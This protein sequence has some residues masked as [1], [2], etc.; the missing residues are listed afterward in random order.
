MQIKTETNRVL[1]FLAAERAKAPNFRSFRRQLVEYGY[2]ISKG[3][4]GLVVETLPNRQT[5]CALPR[6]LHV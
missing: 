3:A 2:C 5:V 6:E 1:D 4:H